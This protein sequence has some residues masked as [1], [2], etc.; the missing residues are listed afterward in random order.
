MLSSQ[1]VLEADYIKIICFNFVLSK[2]KEGKKENT[3]VFVDRVLNLSVQGF[4]RR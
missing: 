2:I 4:K 1:F 3:Q